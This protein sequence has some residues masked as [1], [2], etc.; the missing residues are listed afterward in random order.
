MILVL[1][2]A[3]KSSNNAMEKS[4]STPPSPNNTKQDY[5]WENGYIVFNAEF[6]AK[7][8]PC[9]GNGC[10]HCPYWP[11]HQRGNTNLSPE[12]LKKL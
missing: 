5:Y 2:A 12:V 3:A 4:D 10:R 8:G 11:K 7:R 6:L 9:C 1:V